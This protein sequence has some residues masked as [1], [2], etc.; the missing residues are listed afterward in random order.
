MWLWIFFFVHVAVKVI[1]FYCGPVELR[2]SIAA[3]HWFDHVYFLLLSEKVVDDNAAA[4]QIAVIE[5]EC[6]EYF[7]ENSGVHM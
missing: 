7:T 6:Q 3:L 5:H 4:S 2:T 1:Y